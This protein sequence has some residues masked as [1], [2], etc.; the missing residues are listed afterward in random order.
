MR[1]LFEHSFPAK[2]WNIKFDDQFLVAELRDD[3]T[4]KVY[5]ATI[6]LHSG[7]L[8][9]QQPSPNKTWWQSLVEVQQGYANIV[10]FSADSKPEVIDNYYIELQS[11]NRVEQSSKILGFEGKNT[12]LALHPLHYTDD[13]EFFPAIFKFL[14]R[15]LSIDIQKGV[16]YL[17][18]KDKIIISYYLYC[19]NKLCNYLLVV[20][21]KREILLH[22]LI[23]E[24]EGLGIST[25]TIKPEILLYVKNKCQLHGYEL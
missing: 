12:V 10:E 7:E 20:N 14:Y 19:E 3:I 24:S 18:Y 4:R 16:D 1:Q 9:W 23:A 13:N 25:F 2:I 22:E 21:R 8:L 11:G 6:D 15:L 5:F 17:E